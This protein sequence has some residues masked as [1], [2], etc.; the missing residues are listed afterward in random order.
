[1]GSEYK[2]ILLQRNRRTD[3]LFRNAKRQLMHR[4]TLPSEWRLILILPTRISGQRLEPQIVFNI[5]VIRV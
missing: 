3:I 5:S 2:H 4:H 1:M